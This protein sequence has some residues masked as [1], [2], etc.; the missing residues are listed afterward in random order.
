M[1][2]AKLKKVLILF[3]TNIE[4]VNNVILK[5]AKDVTI[6]TKTNNQFNKKML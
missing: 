6:K 1:L 4:T 3:T 5:A 2:L